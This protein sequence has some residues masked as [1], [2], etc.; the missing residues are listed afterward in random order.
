[1]NLELT[2][3]QRLYLSKTKLVHSQNLTLDFNRAIQRLQQGI[4]Y[5]HLGN[6][7][8]DDGHTDSTNE[9]LKE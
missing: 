3:A 4:T 1:V 5:G 9:R 8:S 6:A 2:S 7:E